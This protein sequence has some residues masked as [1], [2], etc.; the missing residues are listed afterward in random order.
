MKKIMDGSLY[1]TETAKALASYENQ[2]E[3]NSAYFCETLYQTKSGKYFLHGKGGGSTIYANITPSKGYRYNN[4]PG[5]AIRPLSH[6]EARKWAEE[7]LDVEQYMVL[8]EPVD[9]D[10]ETGARVPL[11][12]SVSL[13]CKNKLNRLREERRQ[14]MSVI[15]E[16]LVMESKEEGGA[17]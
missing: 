8:F 16:H 3:Q 6:K 13:A 7:F 12:L 10:G 4:E 1:N 15:V 5:E 11:N 17:S 14:S 2:K 9:E